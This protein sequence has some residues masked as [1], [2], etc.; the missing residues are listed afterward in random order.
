M[1]LETINQVQQFGKERFMKTYYKCPTCGETKGNDVY[2]C[3]ECDHV[4][5]N[6]QHCSYS[7]NGRCAKC[8]A[9][10]TKRQRIGKIK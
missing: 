3:R 10:G 8:D 7:G 2:K 9:L 1:M 5:C 6:H 4:G